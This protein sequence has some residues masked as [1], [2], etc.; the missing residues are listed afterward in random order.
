MISAIT[1]KGSVYI[2]MCVNDINYT[3]L[4]VMRLHINNILVY[5][6]KRF[7]IVFPGMTHGFDMVYTFGFSKR[8]LKI[9]TGSANKTVPPSER[10]ISRALIAILTD[11]SKT[12]YV[13]LRQFMYV[14][15][16]VLMYEGRKCFI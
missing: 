3:R 2:T 15:K 1:V 10:Q 6:T 5:Q 16:Y 12:G 9:F 7:I 14:Y 4:I 8:H 11:F 13:D